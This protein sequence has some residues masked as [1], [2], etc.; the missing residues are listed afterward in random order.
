MI[1]VR[2]IRAKCRFVRVKGRIPLRPSLG[3]PQTHKELL[4]LGK[5]VVSL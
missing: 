4:F 3:F 1:Q 5:S 2:I